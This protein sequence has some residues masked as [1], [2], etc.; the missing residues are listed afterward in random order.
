M[1]GSRTSAGS[2]RWVITVAG[3]PTRATM[4]PDKGSGSRKHS[5][6]TEA[7]TEVPHSEFPAMKPGSLAGTLVQKK[8]PKREF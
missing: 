6:V 7:R 2:W 4:L 3:I 1:V 8:Q 5:D